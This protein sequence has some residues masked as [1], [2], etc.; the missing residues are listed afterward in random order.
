MEEPSGSPSNQGDSSGPQEGPPQDTQKDQRTV[1]SPMDVEGN[2][3]VDEEGLLA[4]RRKK[5]R[6]TKQDPISPLSLVNRH[7]RTGE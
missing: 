5:Q 7:E 3:R 2:F 4:V 1:M 6:R